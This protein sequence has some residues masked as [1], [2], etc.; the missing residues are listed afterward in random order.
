MNKSRSLLILSAVLLASAATLAEM[1]QPKIGEP[2]SPFTLSTLDGKKLSLS[3][4]KG[5]LVVLHFGTGW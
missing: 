1:K 5:N 4:L 3:D 2:A